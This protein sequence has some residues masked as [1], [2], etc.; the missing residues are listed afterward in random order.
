MGKAFNNKKILFIFFIIIL[1]GCVVYLPRINSLGLYRDDWNNYWNAMTRGAGFLKEHYAADRPLDGYLLWILFR[2]F[3]TNNT[4]YLIYN[5]LYRVLGCCALSAAFLLVFQAKEI[6]SLSIGLLAL[7]F[8]GFLQ[9]IEGIS[10]VPHQTAM[11]SFILSLTLTAAAL[12]TDNKKNRIVLTVISCLF[13]LFSIGLMEYYIGMEIVRIFIILAVSSETLYSGRQKLAKTVEQ[14][15]PY[16]LPAA[17]FLIWRIWFFDAQRTGTSVT[18]DIIAPFFRQPLQETAE[19]LV[20]YAKNLWKLFF[21]SWTVP[22]HNLL[23]GLDT[24]TFL[25]TA[26]PAFIAAVIATAGIFRG[27]ADKDRDG[28]GFKLMISGLVIGAVSIFPMVLSKHDI[29]FSLSLDRFSWVGMIGSILLLMGTVTF[30]APQKFR[31][32]ILVFVIFFSAFVQVRN[33]DTYIAQWQSIKDYWQQLMWRAPMLADGTTIVSGGTLIAEED[34]DIFV[35]ANMIYYPKSG[36]Y[37]QIAAEV[38]NTNTIRDIHLGKTS[39]RYTRKIFVSKDYTKLIAI[40]K[41][42]DNA[43]LRV[44]DGDHPIYSP[45]DWTKIP[46]VGSFS[47]IDRILT[48]TD[49]APAVPFFLGKEQEHNWCYYFEKMELALQSGDPETAAA[50][51]DSAAENRLTAGD[52]IELLPV[53]EAYIG[54]GRTGDAG[55]AAQPLLEDEF[56]RSELCRYYTNKGPAEAAAIFCTED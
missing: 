12:R 2:L 22:A 7:F 38:L 32:M 30:I 51:A 43:C 53:I 52:T 44:I 10:Y 11:L 55:S 24:F 28:T 17:A 41:P 9:Q 37:P 31:G 19:L 56:M 13:S 39:E 34:Y 21:G 18:D 15:I 48:E 42:S 33:K 49:F 1:S 46:Q 23:N 20:R 36:E 29:N 40:T 16:L 50:L 5:F 8:P 3:G 26:I 14:Y 25:R 4:A 27:S 35:P 6:S 45:A 54:T 47:R